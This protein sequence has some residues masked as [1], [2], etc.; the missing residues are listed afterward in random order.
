MSSNA[1][2]KKGL[3]WESD[4]THSE[5]KC[6]IRL[7]NY[8]WGYNP[9]IFHFCLPLDFLGARDFK[10]IIKGRRRSERPNQRPGTEEVKF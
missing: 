1:D 3:R 10:K 4:Q 6:Q 8:S 7:G 2:A 5:L 9:Q